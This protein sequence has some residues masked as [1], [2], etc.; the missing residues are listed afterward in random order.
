MILRRTPE[1]TVVSVPRILV[2]KLFENELLLPSMLP[3]QQHSAA[4]AYFPALLRNDLPLPS[5]WRFG[6]A[7]LC[8][9]TRP[10]E[11]L[12]DEIS[13]N[14]WGVFIKATYYIVNLLNRYSV[15][16]RIVPRL[17]RAPNPLR[18]LCH[19]KLRVGSS[20][21]RDGECKLHAHAFY[22]RRSINCRLCIEQPRAWINQARSMC[23][24][25]RV[26]VC[27][28]EQDIYACFYF[29]RLLCRY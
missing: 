8:K 2:L 13:R 27:T 14:C 6:C 5:L 7:E 9:G 29:G 21:R 28:K 3:S 10:L 1:Q 11:W 24:L 16:I 4:H 15:N 22:E 18:T 19:W 12:S 17:S 25:L 26:Y 20:K 23:T